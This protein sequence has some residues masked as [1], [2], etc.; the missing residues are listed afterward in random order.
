[1]PTIRTFAEP[2]NDT[3]TVQIPREYRSYSFEVVLVPFVKE[4]RKPNFVDFL[5]KCP[6]P[7]EELDLSRD[8][9]DGSSRE[10]AFG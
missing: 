8:C 9:D 1:M 2:V 7:A 6:V 5:C 4:K 3:L 10:E